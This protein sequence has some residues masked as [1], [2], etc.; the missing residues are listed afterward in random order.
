[1]VM[2][3]ARVVF[4]KRNEDKSFAYKEETTFAAHYEHEHKTVEY[5][6]KLGGAFELISGALGLQFKK[7]VDTASANAYQS[8]TIESGYQDFQDNMYQIYRTITTQVK[9]NGQTATLVEEKYVDAMPKN[10]SVTN[11]QWE[12]YFEDLA[13]AYVQDNFNATEDDIDK[14]GDG[15]SYGQAFCTLGNNNYNAIIV[16]LSSTYLI[17]FLKG[18]HD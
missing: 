6:L 16:D 18:N 10:D 9:I 7:T 2:V 5:G 1:M 14:S 11:D 15:V 4:S 8:H 3:K 17:S 12:T 13:T